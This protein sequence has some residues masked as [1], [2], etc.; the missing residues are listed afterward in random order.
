[1]QLSGGKGCSAAV[2]CRSYQASLFCSDAHAQRSFLPFPALPTT[3]V[4]AAQLPGAGG[5]AVVFCRV[6]YQGSSPALL[7]SIELQPAAGLELLKCLGPAAPGAAPSAD[8]ASYRDQGPGA[9]SFRDQ[10][11]QVS[12]SRD[13]GG[14]QGVERD[15]AQ[16]A[17]PAAFS[18]EAA[19]GGRGGAGDG[20]LLPVGA[21]VGQ[22]WIVRRRDGGPGE[23]SRSALLLLRV[24]LCCCYA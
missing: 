2:T 14:A 18:G 7:H 23:R 21:S 13:R 5:A 1:M 22:A 24:A 8:V 12:G 9:T 10:G 15:A 3:Q 16:A 4:T 17:G 20:T 6:V 19:G 11:L